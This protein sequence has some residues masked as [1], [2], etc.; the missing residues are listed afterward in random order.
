MYRLIMQGLNLNNNNQIGKVEKV[1]V[2]N[3]FWT[4]AIT[5]THTHRQA[6]I[7]DPRAATFAAK[8]IQ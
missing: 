6:Q 1:K 7:A 4:L 8:K 5:D 2:A 3:Q